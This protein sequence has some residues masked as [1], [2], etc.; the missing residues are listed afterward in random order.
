MRISTSITV[1]LIVLLFFS[2]P[3]SGNYYCNSSNKIN[4][5]NGV[6]AVIVKIKEDYK[7]A[8]NGAAAIDQELSQRSAPLTIK[9]IAGTWKGSGSGWGYTFGKLEAIKLIINT[10]GTYTYTLFVDS[11]IQSQS[12]SPRRVETFVTKYEKT[13][14]YGENK[15]VTYQQGI[16]FTVY[17]GTIKYNF[18]SYK[19]MSPDHVDN[20]GYGLG[21][22]S[23]IILTKENS[24]TANYDQNV[25]ESPSFN[26]VAPPPPPPPP[27]SN[28]I[29]TSN[30]N[31]TKQTA[32]I[33][34]NIDNTGKVFLDIYLKTLRAPLLEEV[35]KRFDITFSP[36]EKE[37]F[38]LLPD[39][40]VSILKMKEFLAIND[41]K[42][43][44]HNLTGI[45]YD[46][47]DNQLYIW[48][49]YANYIIPDLR[50]D[51]QCSENSPSTVI[52]RINNIIKDSKPVIVTEITES[53]S[54]VNSSG[55]TPFVIVEEMPMF[56]GGDV[57][58]T[59]YIDEHI[60][61]PKIAKENNIQGRVIV[62]LCVT[63]LGG[64]SQ[65]S[66]LKSVDPELDKEAIR[67][68]N[69][70]PAFKPGK[71][72]GKPVPVWYM[73]PVIFQSNHK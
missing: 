26:Q 40:G 3:I 43:R 1:L 53:I 25:K 14:P 41:S 10:D 72:G 55:E 46:S 30:S 34:I 6:A 63:A 64:V 62:R 65:V 18:I 7:N 45:P 67:V 11:K 17:N 5:D 12:T 33:M 37:A 59:K 4:N 2:I 51:I 66:I 15:S 27:P 22:G 19:E 16:K 24:V 38:S 8:T 36:P 69:T 61:Y 57:E 23:N 49:L 70:L 58:L 71:Q 20:G 47:T 68:V 35:G 39:V 31:E 73:V 42:E 29:R 32:D 21:I 28:E 13:D 48:M 44:M 50:V 60:N 56:P 9:E 54:N 52:K